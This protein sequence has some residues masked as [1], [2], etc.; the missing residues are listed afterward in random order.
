MATASNT[1]KAFTVEDDSMSPEFT[2]KD[3][4]II[5]TDLKP[6]NDEHV[7][8]RL[9]SGQMLFRQFRPR[10]ET[11]YDLVAVNPEWPTHSVTP[12]A[13]AEILGTLVEHRRK[14]LFVGPP[15]R[16]ARG[17]GLSADATELATFWRKKTPSGAAGD[18]KY[19]RR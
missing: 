1:L 5:D 17:G 19:R 6:D 3:E 7:L 11:S 16:E 10:S 18:K 9:G 4:I 14:R 12:R 15:F 13:P 2:Y 8:V